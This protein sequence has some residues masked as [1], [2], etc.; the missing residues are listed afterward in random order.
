MTDASQQGGGFDFLG[1]HFERGHRWPR[2]KSLKKFKD[3]LRR[4]TRPTRRNQ[5]RSWEEIVGG[6]NRSL[7]GWHEYYQ[8]SEAN[9][10]APLDGFVRR[11]L[12]SLLAK[13]RGRTVHGTGAAHQE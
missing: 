6:V 8:Y 9:V 7:R 13:R 5:G 10:F 11:R 4:P 12:S 3:T 2:E 1:Y